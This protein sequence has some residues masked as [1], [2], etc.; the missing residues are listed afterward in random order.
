[1]TC[2]CAP[3]HPP[4][5]SLELPDGDVCMRSL[6]S[7]A[8]VLPRVAILREV[9]GPSASILYF[10][11]TWQ[12]AGVCPVPDGGFLRSGICSHGAGLFMCMHRHGAGSDGINRVVA[13]SRPAL[14]KPGWSMFGSILLLPNEF[15]DSICCA[16]TRN[17]ALQRWWS[18]WI[19][20]ARIRRWSSHEFS[21]YCHSAMPMPRRGESPRIDREPG[22]APA[23]RTGRAAHQCG[24]SI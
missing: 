18:D 9:A 8:W 16:W 6:R 12:L 24:P 22:G 10:W 20:R 23:V 15:C 19:D 5:V 21:S 2:F 11:S 1:M 3:G 7:G 17:I 13:R 4:G 14:L